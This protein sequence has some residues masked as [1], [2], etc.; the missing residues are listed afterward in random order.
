MSSKRTKIPLASY[1]GRLWTTYLWGSTH[2]IFSYLG[3][4]FY[5]MLLDPQSSLLFLLL[6]SHWCKAIYKRIFVLSWDMYLLVIS[7]MRTPQFPPWTRQ[8]RIGS[9]KQL[10]DLLSNVVNSVAM[11]MNSRQS[12]SIISNLKSTPS[13]NSFCFN[14]NKQ[15][16]PSL[17]TVLYRTEPMVPQLTFI[18]ARMI[19]ESPV[20]PIGLC[21]ILIESIDCLFIMRVFESYSSVTNFNKSIRGARPIT[22]ISMNIRHSAAKHTYRHH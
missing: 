15:I 10:R 11:L 12:S 16:K 14:A 7:V 20:L 2:W 8:A 22:C 3:S 13:G 9:A 6:E 21:H 18:R 17:S 1:T 5:E 19:Q 4:S